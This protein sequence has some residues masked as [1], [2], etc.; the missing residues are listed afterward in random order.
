MG[1]LIQLQTVHGR[2]VFEST[3][4][5]SLSEP[6][7]GHTHIYLH[8]GRKIHVAQD[9]DLLVKKLWPARPSPVLHFPSAFTDPVPEAVEVE[10]ELAE[11]E[12]KGWE[13]SRIKNK[14]QAKTRYLGDALTI[15]ASDTVGG[16][17]ESAR[18]F[19]REVMDKVAAGDAE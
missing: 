1:A 2:V 11:C 19:E 9:L 15:V 12:L 16:L 7:P 10:H 8:D 14:W 17:I 4:V 3:S 13:I 18:S 6:A 5:V